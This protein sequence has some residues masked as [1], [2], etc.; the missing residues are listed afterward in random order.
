MVYTQ[1]IHSIQQ[2]W[3]PTVE[4]DD[5]QTGRVL[6]APLSLSCPPSLLSLCRTVSLYGVRDRGY[7]GGRSLAGRGSRPAQ[8]HE[9]ND[10][11]DSE[12]PSTLELTHENNTQ[13]HCKTISHTSFYIL[14]CTG[15]LHIINAACLGHA[16]LSKTWP[17]WLFQKSYLC[18][19]RSRNL[20]A[21]LLKNSG[22]VQGIYTYLHTQFTHPIVW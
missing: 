12:P 2:W 7:W 21:L 17:A 22:F 15:G 4:D 20:L 1:I 14:Y 18:S 5:Y 13:H 6:V 11:R 10:S 9:V 19:H 8:G 16:F 3:D